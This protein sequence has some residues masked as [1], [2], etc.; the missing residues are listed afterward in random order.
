MTIA[1]PTT[2]T[3]LAQEPLEADELFN[4]YKSTRSGKQRA[5]GVQD[6][7][8]SMGVSA[9]S[10]GALQATSA[11]LP[12][13]N[14]GEFTTIRWTF[15]AGSALS[16]SSQYQH[17]LIE[18]Y[19]RA[20]DNQNGWL[21]VGEVGGAVFSEAFV[22]LNSTDDF[23][24]V[25]S[26]T[27]NVRFDM[28]QL[29]QMGMR[30]IGSSSTIPANSVIKV[31]MAVNAPGI[32][33]EIGTD[34]IANDAVTQAKIAANAVGTNEI[35][36]ASITQ[37]KLA[38]GVGGTPGT[39]A[40]GTSQLA[41]DAVTNPKIANNAVDTDQIADDAVTNVKLAADSVTQAKIAAGAVNTTELA[42]DAVNNAKLAVNAVGTDQVQNASIT[43]AKLAAGVGGTP[44]TGS[45]GTSHLA[46]ASVTT[47]KLANLAV[48]TAKLAGD[49]V[50][51]A[52]IADDSIDG[53]KI[54]RASLDGNRIEDGTVI[55]GKLSA[56]SVNH[57]ALN[58]GIV[59]VDNLAQDVLDR[60]S[61]QHSLLAM[62][63]GH[64]DPLTSTPPWLS[65]VTG[66]YDA[67]NRV[68]PLIGSAANP[69]SNDRNNPLY[70]DN[71]EIE[72]GK[73][74]TFRWKVNF[75]HVA[76]A[77]NHNASVQIFWG[78]DAFT[79]LP[80]FIGGLT[81][82][83]GFW[84]GRVRTTANEIEAQYDKWI[85]VGLRLQNTGLTGSPAQSSGYVQNDDM[86]VT[87][88]NGALKPIQDKLQL[89]D[90]FTR[91]WG[92]FIPET[93]DELDMIVTS[94]NNLIRFYI[95][96]EQYAEYDLTG[97]TGI[98]Y[99][100]RFGW[101]GD[102]SG[103]NGNKA[104]LE[105]A[106]VGTPD[107]SNVIIPQTD[108][109]LIVPGT[110]PENALSF[111]IND[112]IQEQE[113]ITSGFWIT[114]A[115]DNVIS[116]TAWESGG[117]V[118]I[119]SP[120]NVPNSEGANRYLW[121]AFAEDSVY[122]IKLGNTERFDTFVRE[123]TVSIYSNTYYVYRS[124][125][126]LGANILHGN[127]TFKGSRLRDG[128]ITTELLNRQAIIYG[129]ET[130]KNQSSLPS[131]TGYNLGDKIDIGGTLYTLLANT[132]DIHIYHGTIVAN[133]G[134][135][136][137]YFGDDNFR[138]QNVDPHNM[139]GN[140]SKTALGSSP[141]NFLWIKFHAG[142]EYADIKLARSSGHDSTPNNTY[143]YVHAPGTPGLENNMVGDD[144]TLTV[145]SNDA[146]TTPQQVQTSTRW[147]KYNNV[148]PVALQGNHDRWDKDKLPEDTAFT[149]TSANSRGD[150]QATSNTLP[151]SPP[152]GEIR[153]I[154]WTLASGSS[155]GIHNQFLNI[156]TEPYKRA[157]NNQNGW[158]AVSEVNGTEFEEV[159]LGL[160]AKPNAQPLYFSSNQ[161]VMFVDAVNFSGLRVDRGSGSLPA[162]SVIKV[163]EAINAPGI[164]GTIGTDQLTNEAVTYDK[165]GSSRGSLIG[166]SSIL[167]TA[168]QT[169]HT[170]LTGYTWTSTA[171]FGNTGVNFN[172]PRLSQGRRGL[173]VVAE[174][175]GTEVSDLFL[176]W[177][178]SGLNNENEL[179]LSLTQS[180]FIEE[181]VSR[182]SANG[183]ILHILGGGSTIPS[184]TV[185]KIYEG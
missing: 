134:G 168:S 42:D 36:N 80:A 97:I 155:L 138:W 34:Q 60:I 11:T 33:G 96:G 149:D 2:Q 131:I 41:D 129:A 4:T 35:Q 143:G 70:Q 45:I 125:V 114:T 145:F 17:I 115:T 118:F 89:P 55:L 92:I 29:G 157:A 167:P 130:I 1:Q 25:L 94:D 28:R 158:W 139:R 20:E 32:T 18:P 79:N 8:N 164:T 183:A 153:A 128:E 38:A 141:P 180:I 68:W 77:A 50:T 111:D 22:P 109:R 64:T 90:S 150:L 173:W 48:T 7:L 57:A 135:D 177:G 124:N 169:L 105:N 54:Q 99:G 66:K 23:W 59:E 21:F 3:T 171:P 63:E 76:G 56:N 95:N 136:S 13:T 14:S 182:A 82:G 43:Q 12:T 75:S 67:T 5:R 160:N 140:F 165:L 151:T 47:A 103:T 123:G 52:K 51:N 172:I 126:A 81:Q 163:Y 108:G 137:G 69:P 161:S 104:L 30:A 27:E 156:L 112:I 122:S 154:R 178:W 102:G 53:A 86:Y 87:L 146:Y 73:A 88:M 107:P 185:V 113:D 100:P 142:S 83:A 10:R 78:G 44:G 74:F 39:G 72:W 117:T 106:Y 40:I 31:Y 119:A 148:S 116:T 132:E 71:S 162:N 181:E 127:W 179:W 49:S 85:F 16:A 58:S 91:D 159:F 147:E 19:K 15:P 62:W 184:N 110:V 84:C 6:V 65:T 152:S 166:T 133:A 24:V 120:A 101:F 98:T 93:A 170:A 144:F 37:A 9:N 174:I 26:S 61:A 121:W 176:P 46:D 175:N